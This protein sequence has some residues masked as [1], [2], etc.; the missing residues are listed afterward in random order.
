VLEKYAALLGKE[1]DAKKAIK[2]AEKDLEQKVLA[3]YP[4]L[5]LEE[6]KT[7]VVERKWMAAIEEAVQGEVDRLSQKLAGRVKELADRY[8]AP[9]PTLADDVEKLAAKVDGHLKQMG[10]TWR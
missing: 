9:L 3:K 4:K 8:E 6:V 5:P 1:A 10:F 2:E 7:L